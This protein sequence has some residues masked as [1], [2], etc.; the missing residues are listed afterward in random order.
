ME[1]TDCDTLEVEGHLTVRQTLVIHATGKVT[2]KIRYGRIVVE[3]G[4]QLSGDIA[5][6]ATLA[7]KG[8]TTPKATAVSPAIASP[9]PSDTTSATTHADNG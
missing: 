2:G 6:D 1:I 5:V 4:G 8:P 7:T 3:E 9:A